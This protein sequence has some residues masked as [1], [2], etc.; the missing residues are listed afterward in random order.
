MSNVDGKRVEEMR[1]EE[2]EKIK[3]ETESWSL[4]ELRDN[5]A[6]IA[7][8]LMA[9]RSSMALTQIS[10]KHFI[11]PLLDIITNRKGMISAEQEMDV[12]GI[13]QTIGLIVDQD[14]QTQTFTEEEREFIVFTKK[15]LCEATKEEAPLIQRV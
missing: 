5:F 12:D 3:K 11:S 15:F 1:V 14:L 13:Q 8:E 9:I 10:Y 2:V 6:N 4:D 7:L